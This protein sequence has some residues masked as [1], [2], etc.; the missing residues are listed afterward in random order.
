MVASPA[1]KDELGELFGSPIT[2]SPSR[3]TFEDHVHDWQLIRKWG[4]MSP[5]KK[6]RLE[7]R[8]FRCR[9]CGKKRLETHKDEAKI[10]E[11]EWFP[12]GR[13]PP[14]PDELVDDAYMEEK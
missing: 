5:K 9:G 1:H 2:Q 7:W 8:L 12:Y 14:A 4:R 10:K 11:K 3:P 13:Q 6:V